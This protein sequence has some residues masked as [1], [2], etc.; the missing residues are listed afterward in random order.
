[1]YVRWQ[2]I[3]LNLISA[4]NKGSEPKRL[5][6]TIVTARTMEAPPSRQKLDIGEFTTATNTLGAY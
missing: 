6:I 3:V 2:L 5:I 4:P 1:V